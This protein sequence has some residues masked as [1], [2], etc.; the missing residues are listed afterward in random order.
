M[1][2]ESKSLGRRRPKP[3]TSLTSKTDKTDEGHRSPTADE[4]GIPVIGRRALTVLAMVWCAMVFLP[5]API[6][7]A[8][9]TAPSDAQRYQVYL[10][11]YVFGSTHPL[12]ARTW[13]LCEAQARQGLQQLHDDFVLGCTDSSAV[14][15]PRQTRRGLDAWFSQED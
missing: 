6:A 11:G 14:D 8:H 4:P 9:F 2:R 1:A 13:A 5:L 15:R 7:Y 12:D 3:L 10:D